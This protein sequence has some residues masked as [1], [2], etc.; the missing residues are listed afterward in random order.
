MIPRMSLPE[1][2]LNVPDFD[3]PKVE[4]LLTPTKL[5][6]RTEVLTR[7]CQCQ[8]QRAFMHGSSIRVSREFRLKD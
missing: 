3:H 8:R 2:A 7:P 6:T 4:T 1:N 5:L